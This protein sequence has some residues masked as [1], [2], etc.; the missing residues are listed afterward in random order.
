MLKKV[1][2]YTDFNGNKKT[3]AFYFNLTKA[4]IA[5]MEF[6]RRGGLTRY[7]ADITETED[8]QKLVALFKELILKSYGERSEDGERFIKGGDITEGFAQTNAYSELYTEL[9]QN[10]EAAVAFFNGIIPEDMVQNTN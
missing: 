4:E 3:R 8:A 9:S 1:I 7:I 10:A 5:E 2:T 6:S